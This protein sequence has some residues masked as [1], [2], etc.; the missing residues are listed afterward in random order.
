MPALVWAGIIADASAAGR[1][2]PVGRAVAVDVVLFLD[3][4][5]LERRARHVGR[6]VGIGG[7]AGA[8]RRRRRGLRAAVAGIGRAEIFGR[9]ILDLDHAARDPRAGGA[10]RLGRVIVRIGVHD[11]GL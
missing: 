5:A 6:V 4:A 1:I 8:F 7:G 3:L 9:R 11:D 10:A 2:D